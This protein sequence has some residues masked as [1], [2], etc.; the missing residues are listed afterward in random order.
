MT[1][2]GVV[3]ALLLAAGVL[4]AALPVRN[5]ILMI[6]DGCGF[7]TAT[8]AR[9]YSGRPL[10]LDAALCGA[11]KTS[12]DNSII[13]ESAAAATALATGYKTSCGFLAI[14]PSPNGRLNVA[15]ANHLP[16]GGV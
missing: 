12:A 15:P 3:A 9:L 16:A 4:D 5:V 6:P 1:R 7:S 10:A 13:T 14:G 8:L 11:V 2:R